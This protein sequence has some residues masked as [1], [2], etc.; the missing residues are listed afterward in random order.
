MLRTKTPLRSH[1]T[2]LL[3]G[4]VMA[5]CITPSAQLGKAVSV[6]RTADHA[7]FLPADPKALLVLF[8]C[9]GCDTADTRTESRIVDEALAHRVAVL[10]MQFNG[11]LILPEVEADALLND[12]AGVVEANGLQADSVVIGGFSSGGNVSVLLAKRLLQ[13]SDRRLLLK[14][15][16]V[17]DSPLDLAALY[18]VWKRKA[19][20]DSFPTA[21]EEGSMVIAMLDSLIGDPVRDA[22][23]YDELSPVGT[24]DAGIAPLLAT[25]L[26]LYTEPD[27]AWW[28]IN[29][30]DRYEDMNAYHLERLA[31]RL[32]AMGGTRVSF[33]T[34]KDRG[35]QHGRRHPH[36]WS[37][38]EEKDLV[39]WVLG[40]GP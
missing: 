29:R 39:R 13:G 37:I 22:A 40:N 1:L 2:A 12:I 7:F 21:K 36:A 33:I 24:G 19:G 30:G 32:K 16:F 4:W 28:R 26:R 3:F 6:H 5:S 38:V 11:H 25:E 8:P 18:P 35:I 14:G 17:V 34:S 23:R 9:F 31:A 15:V 27:T 10:L 20:Q